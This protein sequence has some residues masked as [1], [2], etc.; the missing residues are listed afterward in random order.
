MLSV[1]VRSNDTLTINCYC[2]K[3]NAVSETELL[4]C[5]VLVS[6]NKKCTNGKTYEMCVT[7]LEN[8]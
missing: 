8:I 7:V 4:T 6:N 2:Y 3:R 5:L 1:L